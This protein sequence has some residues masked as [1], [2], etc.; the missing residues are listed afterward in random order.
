MAFMWRPAQAGVN[1]LGPG[2]EV[3]EAMSARQRKQARWGGTPRRWEVYMTSNV[4]QAWAFSGVRSP[5]EAGTP[6][7]TPRGGRESL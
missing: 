7:Q 1:C 5:W 2:G 4:F 6:A 3:P